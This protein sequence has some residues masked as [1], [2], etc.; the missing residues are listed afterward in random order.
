MVDFR[1]GF[2]K[3]TCALMKLFGK[4]FGSLKG[5][6]TVTSKKI[7]VGRF[8][9][10]CGWKEGRKWDFGNDTIKLCCPN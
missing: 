10:I 1:P 8:I 2:N 6:K 4:L 9:S 3:K 5:R 7:K